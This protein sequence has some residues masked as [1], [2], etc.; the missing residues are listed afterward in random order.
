MTSLLTNAVVLPGTMG[1]ESLPFIIALLVIVFA[2]AT[3]NDM[4]KKR[5]N[6]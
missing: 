6:K 3:L 1:P 2:A 5:K 4:R